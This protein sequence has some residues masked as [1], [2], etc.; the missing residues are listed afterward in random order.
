MMLLPVA[1]NLAGKSTLVVGGGNVA[2]RKVLS[3]LECGAQVCV[4]APSLK[5][6]FVELRARIKY[7]ERAWQS[8][9][10][11]LENFALVFACTNDREVNAQIASEATELN[12]WCNIGDDAA[13][14]DFH[15]AAAVRRG[16]ICIGITTGGG[17]PALSRALKSQVEK[18][19]GVE[20]SLLLEMVSSRRKMLDKT[21]ETQPARAEVWRAILSSSVLTLLKSG[22]RAAAQNLIDELMERKS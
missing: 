4:I 16:D 8:D 6:E 5:D 18:C 1:L 2:A 3:L 14:S 7:L 22:D 10:L 19:I 12:M 11:R 9:D 15:S 17:S 13:S 21:I 20:W